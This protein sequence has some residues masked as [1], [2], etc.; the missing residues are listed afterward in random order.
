MD[1]PTN[2]VTSY[3]TARTILEMDADDVFDIR[4]SERFVSKEMLLYESTLKTI[5]NNKF[6]EQVIREHYYC[7]NETELGEMCGKIMDII[8]NRL[9]I[10]RY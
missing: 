3:D 8:S 2:I 1:Y 10:K 7:I 5:L 4:A 9:T 6:I